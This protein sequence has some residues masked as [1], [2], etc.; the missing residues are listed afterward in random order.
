MKAFFMRESKCLFLWRNNK[1]CTII[2]FHTNPYQEVWPSEENALKQDYNVLQKFKNK[3]KATKATNKAY[4]ETSSGLHRLL[5]RL[6][7]FQPKHKCTMNYPIKRQSDP[8]E[9]K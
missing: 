8:A 9:F 4:T 6:T 5:L 3:Q 7:E 1:N 2:I